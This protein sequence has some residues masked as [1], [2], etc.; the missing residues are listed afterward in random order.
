MLQDLKH[1]ARMLLQMKGWTAVVLLSLGLGIGANTALFSGVNGMFLRTLSIPHPETLV[2][3]RWAGKNDMNRSTYGYGNTEKNA[4]GEDTSEAFSYS[5]YQAM[6]A[7]NQT[8]VDIAVSA[9]AQQLN[10]IFEGK[11]EVASSLLVSGNYFKVLDV[12]PQIGRLIEPAD[13]ADSASPVAVISDAYW[14]KR[15]GR[16]PR[17]VGKTVTLGKLVFTIVGVTPRSFRGI[18]DLTS[19]ARDVTAPLALDRELGGTRLQEPT[20][21]WLQMVG[22][23]KP[24]AAYPQVR[25]N[26][27]GTFQGAA[28]DG[29]NSYFASITAEQRSLSRNQN[30]TAVPHLEVDSASRGIYDV[31]SNARKSALILSVVVGLVLVIVCANVTN[32]LLSRAAGR[33]KEISVRLSLGATRWRLMRQLLTESLLLSVLGGSLG[34]LVGYWSRQLLPFA[35]EAPLDWHVL[36]FVAGLCL[37]TGVAFGLVP[38]LR[39]TRIDLSGS[40]KEGSRSIIRSRTVLSKALLVVQVAISLIVLVGAGLF[41][42]TL[43][44]LRDVDAGFNTRNLIVFGVNPRM[45]AYEAVRVADL[46]DRL[47]QELSEIPGVTAVSHSQSTLLSGSTSI[48]GMYVQGKSGENP[49]GQQIWMMTVSPEFFQTLQIPIVRGRSF[50]ARDVAPEAPPVGV[51]NETAARK[52]FAGDDPIGKRFGF[53]PEK[54]SEV[55]IIGILRDTK[56]NSLRDETPP[57]L[58]R[59]FARETTQSASFEVRTGGDPKSLIQ[60]VRAAVQKVD[61]SLPVARMT[62]QSE[63][64]EGRFSQEHFFAM[65]FSLFGALALL[66]ASI[67][68]FGLMSYSVA[69]RTNEIGIRMALG[70]QRSHVLRMVV[71]ESLILVAIGVVIGAGAALAAGHLVQAMLFGLAPTDPITMVMAVL[72]MLVVSLLAG[73]LPARRA[74]KVDPM[75]ALRYD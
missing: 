2:R 63:L 57:T 16:D 24:G 25:G 71:S 6:L 39:A 45:N 50:E 38:A 36:G 51:I 49:R 56:Y 66:L 55:E 44:N 46:Y 58:Y 26:L 4:A 47:T 52:Y 3:L 34:I 23:L 5:A 48:S 72:T 69:R 21:W 13:D 43:Q 29:W 18:Q 7:A 11:A 41:L 1:A 62:T 74:S 68:L 32:L 31:G 67:G 12:R 30:R 28:R 9:P 35:Q 33:Q 53:S 65:S 61:S 54:D 19:S 17:I 59:P 27:E 40:M 14:E 42:R 64:V 10:V 22:R 15:F 73:Y 20:T 37:A 8:L 60:F 75:V 70:A